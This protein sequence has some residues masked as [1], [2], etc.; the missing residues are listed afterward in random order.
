ME[1]DHVSTRDHVDS[2]CFP[3]QEGRLGSS[4]M[5]GHRQEQMRF[6]KASTLM[7]GGASDWIVPKEPAVRA[8]RG[9][10]AIQTTATTAIKTLHRDLHNSCNQKS[11]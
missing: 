6:R 10:V 9:T 2:L 8:S 7:A 11:F 1:Q 3:L 5:A 4:G